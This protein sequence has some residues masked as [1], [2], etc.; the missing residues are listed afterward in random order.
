MSDYSYS[1]ITNSVSLI[2]DGHSCHSD[3]NV[4]SSA[5]NNGVNAM[6]SNLHL[7]TTHKLQHSDSSLRESKIVPVLN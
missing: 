5:Q 7:H 3:I 2:A 1:T 6:P 4:T